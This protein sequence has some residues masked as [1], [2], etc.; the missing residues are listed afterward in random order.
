[1]TSNRL[2]IEIAFRNVT[3]IINCP[4]KLFVGFRLQYII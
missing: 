4:L 2:K 3:N 1:M